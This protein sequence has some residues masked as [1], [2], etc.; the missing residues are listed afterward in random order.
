MVPVVCT[1]L[2]GLVSFDQL[3]S[4]LLTRVPLL[5]LLA[6]KVFQIAHGQFLAITGVLLEQGQDF[7]SLGQHFVEHHKLSCLQGVRL[8]FVCCL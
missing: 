3:K 8:R 5:L 2:R 1:L 7:L 4:V 6:E